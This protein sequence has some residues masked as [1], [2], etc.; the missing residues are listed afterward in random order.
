[1]VF[2]SVLYDKKT[3]ESNQTMIAFDGFKSLLRNKSCELKAY[4]I[5]S[6]IRIGMAY[7]KGIYE[8]TQSTDLASVIWYCY[9]RQVVFCYATVI[10]QLS[11][12]AR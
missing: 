3:V 2:G 4:R 10:I 5:C 6:V 8:H 11:Q 9:A 1:M 12:L 7:G